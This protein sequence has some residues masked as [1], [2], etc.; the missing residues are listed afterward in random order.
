LAE[1]VEQFGVAPWR[2]RQPALREL[3]ARIRESIRGG[4]IAEA[5]AALRRLIAPGLDYTSFQTLY[6]LYKSLPVDALGVKTKV[7]VL[8]GAVTTKL[9]A[10]IELALFAM[11]GAVEVIETDYGV[12][13][14]EILDPA[15]ALY[16]QRPNSIFLATSWRELIHRPALTST[17]EEVSQFVDAEF[18]H[19]SALWRTAHERLGCQIIQ[20]NFDRPAWRQLGNH[21]SRQPGGLGRFVSLVN[22]SFA[23]RA[24]PYV[25]IHDLDDLAASAGRAVW[26]D[27]RL[28]YHAKMPCPPQ[29]L[30]EYGFNVASL[31]AAQMGLAKKCLV[32]DLDNTLW[33]GVIGD[34]G[35][36]GIRLG[37][38]EGEGEAFLAFQ[39]YAKALK[40]RGILLA[41]CSKNTEDVAREVFLKHPEM[42]LRLEDIAC[43]MANWNDKAANLR[44]IARALNIG[45]NSLVFADDNP[46]ERALVRQL[47]PEVAV[48]ELPADPADYI[49]AIEQHRYFQITSLGREDVQRAEYYRA[50]AQRQQMLGG[51]ENVEDFLASLQMVARIAPVDEVSLERTAQ[52]INK[53]N[54]FNLT[55]RRRA[56]AEV[57][58]LLRDPEWFTCTV[59]LRD[60]FG[61]NGLISVL[62]AA[63]E[64]DALVIDTWLMSCRVLKRGVETFVHNYLCRWALQHGIRRIRGEYHPTAKNGIVKD[65]YAGLGFDKVTETADGHTSWEFVVDDAWVP[66][67]TQIKEEDLFLQ[68]DTATLPVMPPGSSATDRG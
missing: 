63:V 9:A 7:A 61:D 41:V 3:A 39:R 30:V 67:T 62:L 37:Q 27:E 26:G 50:N 18:A 49:Q 29:H 57:L 40:D 21:E 12:Y 59:S 44:E 33:G 46:A 19:W 54:Q 64:D 65:H 55:T 60:R 35:L 23:D 17:C 4:S 6:R 16:E 14:Q 53:S 51:S 34:D 36:G 22:Q 28:Y 38:G 8:G 48:P 32:L 25:V 5:M 43:F 20:N 31:L 10:A 47:A 13:R 66:R 15:S 56:A 24:P 45:L 58:A 11:G 68:L 1:A 2:E 52:L 42:V